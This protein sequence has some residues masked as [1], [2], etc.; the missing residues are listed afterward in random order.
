MFCCFIHANQGNFFLDNRVVYSR[1]L[2]TKLSFGK[3]W[4]VNFFRKKIKLY[5]KNC[6][7]LCM[8]NGISP[9]SGSKPLILKLQPTVQANNKTQLVTSIWRVWPCTRETTQLQVRYWGLVKLN[10]FW[11]CGT[12]HAFWGVTDIGVRKFL[13]PRISSRRLLR[14]L[15]VSYW[16]SCQILTPPNILPQNAERN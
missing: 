11:S 12:R 13:A 4:M 9:K 3:K 8:T 7:V 5:R 1:I 6:D 2:T 16:A 10:W 14:E 15:P